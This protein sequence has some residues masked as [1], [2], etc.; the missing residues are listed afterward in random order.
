M[1]RTSAS[2][3][4]LLILSTVPP[5]RVEAQ[6]SA[7]MEEKP[8]TKL[9]AFQARL[10]TVIVKEYRRLDQ[11]RSSGG[12]GSVE[13]IAVELTDAGSGARQ[14]GV[15]VEVAE[16]GTLQN[17]SRAYVDADEIE[18]LLQGIDRLVRTT[19]EDTR[20]GSF[21]ATYT[22]KGHLCVTIFSDAGE[23]VSAAVR[24]GSTAPAVVCLSLKDLAELR[25]G[26]AAAK[27]LLDAGR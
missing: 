14:T 1:T 4:L 17:S 19:A 15:A 18:A 8:R 10:G 7:A 20:L 23:R 27:E 11:V 2:L 13:V 12:F 3:T 26:I 22:T 16:G 9:E 24:S 5:A 21:E 25:A 6:P